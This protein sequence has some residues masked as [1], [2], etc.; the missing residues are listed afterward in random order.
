MEAPKEKGPADPAVGVWCDGYRADLST[1]TCGDWWAKTDK[2]VCMPLKR[3]VRG[4][5][6]AKFLFDG[7]TKSEG[8]SVRVSLLKD[9]RTGGA[10]S[11]KEK[12]GSPKAKWR[13]RCQCKVTSFDDEEMSKRLIVDL[14][15]MYCDGEVKLADLNK[16]KS[17]GS[18]AGLPTNRTRE[19]EKSGCC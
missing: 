7:K 16:K 19:N 11:M 10:W 13:S 14:A 8:N 15:K 2:Q 6:N 12:C 3:K 4:S 18:G 9:A 5:G 17:T 1:L